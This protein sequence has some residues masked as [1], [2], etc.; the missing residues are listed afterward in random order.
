MTPV[1][2]VGSI[3]LANSEEVLA[4]SAARL[5]RVLTRF[6]D[7][8]TGPRTGWI[9]WQRAVFAASPGLEPVA[10]KERDY[11]LFPPFRLKPGAAPEEVRLG[12]LGYAEEAGA[13][14]AIF[15]RL[16]ETGRIAPAARLQISL[17]TPFAPAYSFLAYEAQEMIFPLYEAAMLAEVAAITRLVPADELAIQWDVATEMSIWEDVY[18]VTFANPR[19]ELIRRLVR[20]GATVPD[21]V[22]LAYHLCYGSMN[23]RHW[24][25]PRDT[26][27]LTEVANFLLAAVPR[28]ID[29]LHLPVPIDRD[30]DAYFAP[31]DALE[32]PKGTE[33]F[34]GLLHLS[35][36]IRGAARRADAA[37]RHVARFGV[38]A[39]CGLGRH[40][41]DVVPAWL[42]LH[43]EAASALF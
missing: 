35:D 2:L 23:N 37:R 30:D 16:K 9:A 32:L 14:Y 22:E 21:G 36:G 43:E 8:E 38:A 26:G 4:A 31:L 11:Q 13:A 39:E 33:L 27:K 34:L 20:L 41:S 25:E 29:W 10:A 40:P 19:E 7:G 17:P 6:P 12:T 18:P 28:R 1:L 3:P 15:R 42:A 24:R 5:G